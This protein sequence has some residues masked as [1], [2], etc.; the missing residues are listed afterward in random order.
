MKLYVLFIFLSSVF[1]I[2]SQEVASVIVSDS[3][4]IESKIVNERRKINIW[5]PPNYNVVKDSF[6]IIYL[7]DGGVYED[8]PH[9]IETIS[10]LIEAKEMSPVIVVGIENTQRRRDMTGNTSVKSDMKIAPRIGGSGE[11]RSFIEKEL[12]PEVNNRYRV[13]G[14][15]AILGESLAG[16]FVLE[17]FFLQSTLFDYYIAMDPSL[18]WNEH[19][20]VKNADNLLPESFLNEKKLW[21]AGSKTKTIS[22]HT[23]KLAK[24]LKIKQI[25]K[26]EWDYSYQPKEEHGTIYKATKIQALTWVFGSKV[27]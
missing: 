18:W 27:N 23:E 22:K 1:V 20:L 14:K 11:F 3:F 21:F 15:K 19:H 9:I 8:Y 13:T 2:S 4:V 26:L 24:T 25:K 7:L 16:L 17:T 5:T 12:I 10:K 6:P